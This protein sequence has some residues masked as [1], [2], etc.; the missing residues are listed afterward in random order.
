MASAPA[1]V[2]LCTALWFVAARIQTTDILNRYELIE[3][4]FNAD[5]YPTLFRLG[6]KEGQAEAVMVPVSQRRH[7]AVERVAL[8]N[9]D[10]IYYRIAMLD[11]DGMENTQLSDQ[12]HGFEK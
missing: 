4:S 6:L 5:A 8:E 9:A 7:I 10:V 3:D 11:G 2:L 12:E 1:A